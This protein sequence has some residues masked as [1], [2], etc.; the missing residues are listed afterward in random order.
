MNAS[1]ADLLAAMCN[2]TWVQKL[3]FEFITN[4]T[5]TLLI[6]KAASRAAYAAK[7]VLLPCAR[8]DGFSGV[9]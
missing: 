6:V 1:I 5:I 9:Y 8:A 2:D 7:R 4:F 3:A